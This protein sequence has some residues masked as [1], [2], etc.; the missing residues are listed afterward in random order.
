MTAV[1]PTAL[2]P[3]ALHLTL[4]DP[5]F[6]AVVGP[7]PEHETI[8]AGY[9]FT[10]GPVWHPRDGT[11]VF[12]D[13]P[14]DRLHRW[15]PGRPVEVLREPSHMANGN[16]LDR[17]GRLLTCEHATS[18]VTRTEPDRRL[19]VIASHWA[20]KQLNSPN[21]IVVRGDGRVYFT[22]PTY[23]REAETGV[24]RDPELAFQGVY[25][26]DPDGRLALVADDFG[27]PNGL[28]FTPDERRLYVNDTVAGTIRV[29]EVDADGHARGG[30]VWA[31]VPEGGCDGMKVDRLGNVYCCGNAGI[32][33]F[34]A[35]ATPLG[36]LGF[37]RFAANLCFGGDDARWLY[38]T[39]SDRV[40][41]LR[42]ATPGLPV[43]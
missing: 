36:V 29:F 24:A 2:S 15:R 10:E 8:G 33:V 7:A 13:I 3:T 18:R 28:A 9:A 38:V 14:A 41:R 4:F 26:V 1:P 21:D 31:V 17:A 6:A 11:L 23:G 30:A 12:S 32:H 35:D 20:G 40:V 25:R 42:V 19:T 27:Q 16:T 22:D 39:L 37:D 5:R 34:A 43:C